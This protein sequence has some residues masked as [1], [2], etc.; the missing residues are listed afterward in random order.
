MTVIPTSRQIIRPEQCDVLQVVTFYEQRLVGNQRRH[1]HSIRG[2]RIQ[3]IV[4]LE[5]HKTSLAQSHELNF[6]DE[7]KHHKFDLLFNPNQDPNI[8]GH[9][10]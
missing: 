4:F 6:Q 1:S 7:T 10:T 5:H 8:T 3:G 2:G 9:R